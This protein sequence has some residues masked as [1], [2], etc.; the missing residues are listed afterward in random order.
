[1]RLGA[2]SFGQLFGSLGVEVI[3]KYQFYTFEQ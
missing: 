3:Y 2:I 1:M